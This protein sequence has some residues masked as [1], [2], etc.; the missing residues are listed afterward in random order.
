MRVRNMAGA[1]EYGKYPPAA[2]IS[3]LEIDAGTLQH[4]F[5][6]VIHF[7]GRSNCSSF[8]SRRSAGRPAGPSASRSA[9]IA[10]GYRLRRLVAGRCA[11]ISR[12]FACMVLRICTLSR[13]QSPCLKLPLRSPRGPPEPFAPPCIRHLPRPLTAACRH[14]WPARVFAAQRGALAKFASRR[15]MSA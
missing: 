6:G 13:V 7:K 12:I 1:I 15:Q 9:P 14:G 3:F 5:R 4:V 11:L 8:R 10:T 2:S